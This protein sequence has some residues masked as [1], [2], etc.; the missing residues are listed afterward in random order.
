MQTIG[1]PSLYRDVLRDQLA[2]PQPKGLPEA[3]WVAS[4]ADIAARAEKHLAEHF[5]KRGGE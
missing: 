4:C 1:A 5:K 2:K 3:E